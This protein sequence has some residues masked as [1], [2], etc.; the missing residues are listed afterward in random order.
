MELKFM[1]RR[2]D[3]LGKEIIITAIL[4]TIIMLGYTLFK[5]NGWFS[6]TT[7]NILFPSLICIIFLFSIFIS[8]KK[9]FVDKIRNY[10]SDIIL[11][12][13]LPMIFTHLLPLIYYMIPIIA[14][15]FS[16][17]KWYLIT[18]NTQ[19]ITFLLFAV[20]G[21]I[22]LTKAKGSTKKKAI[23]IVSVIFLLF[24]FSVL[25]LSFLNLGIMHMQYAGIYM[26][27]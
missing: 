1:K 18:M 5:Q 15:P 24:T 27:F 6:D 22:G 12:V 9:D 7:V 11:S 4:S 14:S 2:T 23:L 17:D 16:P 26:E 13:V 25:I 8:I 19:R 10:S 20:R 3:I 21:I